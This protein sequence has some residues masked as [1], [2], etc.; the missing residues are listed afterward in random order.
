MWS[1]GLGKQMTH[2]PPAKKKTLRATTV[3]SS[4]AA[5]PPS[6]NRSC[7]TAASKTAA[8]RARCW[9]TFW[10]IWPAQEY[11]LLEIDVLRFFS[12]LVEHLMMFDLQ[13]G[14]FASRGPDVLCLGDIWCSTSSCDWWTRRV[15][16]QQTH[17]LWKPK[18][19]ST[20]ILENKWWN[21]KKNI[22]QT[23]RTWS[24]STMPKL[25]K[26]RRKQSKTPMISIK[27]AAHSKES[28][29]SLF[30]NR[31]VVSTTDCIVKLILYVYSTCI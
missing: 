4:I 25:W 31:L 10:K 18:P 16:G 26:P 8:E 22:R 24:V 28:S 6:C 2:P 23:Q 15:I 11:I 19:S 21:S 29:E 12:L 17:N 13:A 27:N 3:A 9:V 20:N 1:T 14:N 30:A 5:G 7:S